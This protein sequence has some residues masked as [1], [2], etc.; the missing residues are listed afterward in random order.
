[1]TKLPAVTE[2]VALR[3]LV[4]F[5]E[6]AKELELAPEERNWAKVVTLP[7]V[8]TPRAVFKEPPKEEEPVPRTKRLPPMEA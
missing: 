8:W 1:M 7:V 3:D 2:V 4:R 6:P 5:R